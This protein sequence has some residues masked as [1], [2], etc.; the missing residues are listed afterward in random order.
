MEI[1]RMTTTI[2]DESNGFR[3]ALIPMALSSSDLS[4][5]S[6][7]HSTLAISCY[8]LGRPQQAFKY[9]FRAIKDLSDSFNDLSIETVDSATKTRLFA[10]SMMLCVY[11]VCSSIPLSFIRWLTNQR[12]LTSPT[13]HGRCI[14]KAQNPS[15]IRYLNQ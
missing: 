15:T 2:D 10:A 3:L 4:A 1:A 8:H 5:R 12:F 6:M 7:L 9:K 14:S 13:L 11:G